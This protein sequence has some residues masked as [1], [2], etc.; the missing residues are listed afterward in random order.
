MYEESSHALYWPVVLASHTFS[1]RIG[2]NAYR[3]DVP[4]HLKALAANDRQRLHSVCVGGTGNRY[5]AHNG[6]VNAR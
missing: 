3:R 2:P 4:H 5:I 6:A 1:G